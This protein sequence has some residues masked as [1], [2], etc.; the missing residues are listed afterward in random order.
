MK[1][2]MDSTYRFPSRSFYLHKMAPKKPVDIDFWFFLCVCVFSHF[3]CVWLFVTL[4]TVAHQA[5]LSMGFSRQE[6]WSGLSFP[7]PGFRLH[8]GVEP[9]VPAMQADSSPTELPG[10]PNVLCRASNAHSSY[11]FKMH[12]VTDNI[13]SMWKNFHGIEVNWNQFNVNGSWFA[14]LNQPR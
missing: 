4:Q 5:P 6:Y 13:N 11:N 12:Y 8:P 7:P 3:S 10:K 9:G 1:E 2:P 14:L